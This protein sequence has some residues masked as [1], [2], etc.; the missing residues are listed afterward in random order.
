MTAPTPVSTPF[1]N[2]STVPAGIPHYVETPVIEHL[3]DRSNKQWLKLLRKGDPTFFDSS[4]AVRTILLHGKWAF[5]PPVTQKRNTTGAKTGISPREFSRAASR[6]TVQRNALFAAESA[7]RHL[8]VESADHRILALRPHPGRSADSAV[9]RAFPPVCRA[10]AGGVRFILGLYAATRETPSVPSFSS[11]TSTTSNSR[12]GSCCGLRGKCSA[13]AEIAGFATFSRNCGA[14]G[15]FYP[16]GRRRTRSRNQPGVSATVGG[17][18]DET[19]ASGDSRSSPSFFRGS[20]ILDSI[21]F[22]VW[23]NRVPPAVPG[24][25]YYALMRFGVG[26]SLRREMIECLL[27]LPFHRVAENSAISHLPPWSLFLSLA[28]NRRLTCTCLFSDRFIQDSREKD[29]FCL[30]R[31]WRKICSRPWRCRSSVT[32]SRGDT[33]P[34]ST[35]TRH[36]TNS[37]SDWP[38]RFPRQPSSVWAPTPTTPI[39]SSTPR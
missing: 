29:R 10:E 33:S 24:F 26:V 2:S 37:R 1:A 15:R 35:G 4:S 16:Q 31:K 3:L 32:K 11:P 23:R 7:H 19:P 28:P 22:R 5:H 9:A 25:S 36:V 38:T 13:M 18:F 12:G 27:E 21:V 14:N 34:S 20:F 17:N 6:G 30:P 8:H 39:G